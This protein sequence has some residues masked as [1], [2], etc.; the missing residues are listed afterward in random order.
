MLTTL[1]LLS[2]QERLTQR[3]IPAVRESP[4]A[5]DV[6]NTRVARFSQHI[7]EPQP[8]HS[9]PA[10]TRRHV[11]LFKQR[12]PR[13]CQSVPDQAALREEQG[14]A[15]GPRLLLTRRV[16]CEELPDRLMCTEPGAHGPADPR[17]HVVR[18]IREISYE[19]IVAWLGSP[20][21]LDSRKL[22]VLE[23]QHAF[24]SPVVS[25]G[26]HALSIHGLWMGE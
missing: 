24:A 22:H 14:H 6:D 7:H 8:C 20:P 9:R 4:L 26:P 12:Q 23:M 10:E 3:R 17:V 25:L 15:D 5:E 2:Q 18:E 11:L 13:I 21:N 1:S 19:P 16:V